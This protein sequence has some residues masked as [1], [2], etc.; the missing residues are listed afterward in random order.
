M[1]LLVDIFVYGFLVVMVLLFLGE[2]AVCID[3]YLK[4]KKVKDVEPLKRTDPSDNY[5]TEMN[6]VLDM[7]KE[8]WEVLSVA[9]KEDKQEF[10]CMSDSSDI[11]SLFRKAHQAGFH[12]TFEQNDARWEDDP[13][14]FNPDVFK[15]DLG[16]AADI[17][18]QRQWHRY[19][20]YKDPIRSKRDRA[21]GISD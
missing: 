9:A 21:L 17:R 18:E 19:K 3:V 16:E 6:N 7:I 14:Y 4:W 20:R 2:V 15:T 13:E 11:A 5:L 10:D 1:D 12:V 8:R